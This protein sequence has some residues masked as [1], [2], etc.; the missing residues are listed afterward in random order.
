MIMKA[1][2]WL[3]ITSMWVIDYDY[4]VIDYD[5]EV[6][7]YD[8]E[9]INDDYEVIVVYFVRDYFAMI[10]IRSEGNTVDDVTWLCSFQW[11]SLFC[12]IISSTY[13]V[14]FNTKNS[15]FSMYYTNYT[16]SQ[17]SIYGNILQKK[18]Q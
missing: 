15:Y 13:T 3:L 5:Y 11:N 18:L 10:I 12:W 9:V 7:D 6:I 16:Y 1:I 4:E 2:I 14:Q 17:F 8:Y